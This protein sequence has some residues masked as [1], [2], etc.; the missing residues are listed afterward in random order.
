M[1][2]EPKTIAETQEAMEAYRKDMVMWRGGD[3]LAIDPDRAVFF[4]KFLEYAIQQYHE[5]S[6]TSRK[7]D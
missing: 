4:H 5:L 2:T 1:D 7:G 3:G 6:E